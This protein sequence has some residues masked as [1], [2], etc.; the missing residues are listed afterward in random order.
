MNSD[1]T[2]LGGSL[3]KC[4]LYPWFADTQFVS[5]KPVD[6]LVEMTIQVLIGL[7]IV[8]DEL[9]LFKDPI[10]VLAEYSAPTKRWSWG[11]VVQVEGWELVISLPEFAHKTARRLE[12]IGSDLFRLPPDDL[13]ILMG[14]VLLSGPVEVQRIL[15]GLETRRKSFS[16]EGNSAY[17]SLVCLLAGVP[18]CRFESQKL[19]MGSLTRTVPPAVRNLF[20]STER[21]K[22][23]WFTGDGRPIGNDD[24]INPQGS[25]LDY[26]L[27]RAILAEVVQ[28]GSSEYQPGFTVDGRFYRDYH[29]KRT[30]A[31][32]REQIGKLYPNGEVEGFERLHELRE[33]SMYLSELL[34]RA[35]PQ[36]LLFLKDDMV[37]QFN[38]PHRRTGTLLERILKDDHSHARSRAQALNESI[39]ANKEKIRTGR[40]R[41][42]ALDAELKSLEEATSRNQQALQGQKLAFESLTRVVGAF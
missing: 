4:R 13:Y 19:T 25:D 9:D 1:P 36:G 38:P 17:A 40:I 10:Q 34:F 33:S 8:R 31:E 11:E 22:R 7:S 20:Q 18:F 28:E 39:E 42:T 32:M 26:K 37:F 12:L 15:D 30:I 35:G 29:R 16:M 2:G 24:L 3:H 21:E 14:H 23:I 6:A 41:I 27:A 5:A